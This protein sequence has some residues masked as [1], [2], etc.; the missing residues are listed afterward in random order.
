L[1][2]GAG[3][4]LAANDLKVV[5]TSGAAVAVDLTGATTI[6]GVLTAIHAASPRLTAT[7]NTSGNGIDIVDSTASSGN[8]AASSTS[9]L[10]ADLGLNVT[11]SGT[12][13]HGNAITGG[14]V[15]LDGGSTVSLDLLNDG[16]GVRRTNADQ[17]DLTT[18]TLLSALDEGDGVHVVNGND[19]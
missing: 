2:H 6:G 4:N 5:L 8:V 10:A 7:V 18:S 16:T 11:G 17:F 14:S 9:S 15:T 13:L 1:N 19:F 3:A 12:T